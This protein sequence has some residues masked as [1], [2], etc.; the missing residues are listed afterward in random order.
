[1]GGAWSATVSLCAGW[2]GVEH[3]LSQGRT[4]QVRDAVCRNHDWPGASLPAS[5]D[6]DRGRQEILRPL[7]GEGGG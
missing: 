6:D 5:G 4:T 7:W 3:D 1:M 2:L